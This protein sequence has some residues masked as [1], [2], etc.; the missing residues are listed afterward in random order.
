MLNVNQVWSLL[1]GWIVATIGR[2]WNLNQGGAGELMGRNGGVTEML[3]DQIRSTATGICTEE[4][5]G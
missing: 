1:V 3:L 4:A 2:T 5:A